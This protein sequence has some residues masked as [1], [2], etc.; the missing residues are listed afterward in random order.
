[1][2]VISWLWLVSLPLSE[3]NEC[4]GIGLAMGDDIGVAV[5]MRMDE[6]DRT[7]PVRRLRL[8]MANRE[9]GKGR[10]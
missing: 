3:P 8:Y 5:G 1:L 7:A 4:D 9:W 6:R 10:G 2:S